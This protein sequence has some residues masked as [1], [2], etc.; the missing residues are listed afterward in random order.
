MVRLLFTSE[1]AL[2]R[3]KSKTKDPM[4]KFELDLLKRV[5]H[6]TKTEDQYVVLREDENGRYTEYAFKDGWPESNRCLSWYN[7]I[8]PN[9]LRRNGYTVEEWEAK[10]AE[11]LKV[12]EVYKLSMFTCGEEDNTE[13]PHCQCR[14]GRPSEFCRKNNRLNH[15]TID[16]P[17][18]CACWHLKPI[19]EDDKIS[20]TLGELSDLMMRLVFNSGVD[21]IK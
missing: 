13:M 14:P 7:K 9:A 1:R 6:V 8:Q 11:S 4:K 21:R 10:H 20:L 12:N 16:E 15:W 2:D 5:A 3:I 19:H 17:C 18:K